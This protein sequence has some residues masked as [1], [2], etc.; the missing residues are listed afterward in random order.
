MG[1]Y[2]NVCCESSARDAATLGLR[3]LLTTAV[4][5]AQCDEN[6]N[7]ALHPIYPSCGDMRPRKQRWT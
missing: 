2:T 5:A 3:V 1:T 6:H 4:N 7:A